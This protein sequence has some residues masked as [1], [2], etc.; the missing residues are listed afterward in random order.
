MD[1]SLKKDF[2][3]KAYSEM[4]KWKSKLADKYALLI[5]GA[6]RVGK[7]TLVK[8]FVEAEYDSYIYIDFSKQDREIRDA[9]RA[10]EESNGVK[11]L[12]SRLELI[13]LVKMIP[14]RSCLVFDEVQLFPVAR[15]MIKHFVEFFYD[16]HD[17]FL[18]QY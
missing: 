17:K 5:E 16:R 2:Y 4:L 15:G 7:T 8:R 14:G 10:I 13:F 18:Q 1:D 3:R 12:I 11:D 6:R 9:K